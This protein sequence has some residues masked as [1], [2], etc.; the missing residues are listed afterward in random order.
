MLVV[1]SMLWSYG[2]CC[3]LVIAGSVLYLN[4]RNRPSKIKQIE[5]LKNALLSFALMRM[6]KDDIHEWNLNYEGFD[7]TKL[8]GFC[9]VSLDNA[10]FTYMRSR[11]ELKMDTFFTRYLIKKLGA[12]E[13]YVDKNLNT[14]DQVQAFFNAFAYSII[15]HDNKCKDITTVE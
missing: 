13:K 14:E 3:G 12:I 2:I 11:E 10:C 6:C 9:G 7:G 15:T 8:P 4:C 5:R 1:M